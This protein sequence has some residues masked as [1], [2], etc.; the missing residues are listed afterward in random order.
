M[1]TETPVAMDYDLSSCCHDCC[2]AL[3]KWPA[4]VMSVVKPHESGQL[5]S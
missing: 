2:Q 3:W 5:L 4:V 1:A